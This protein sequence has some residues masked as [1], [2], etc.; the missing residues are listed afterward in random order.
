MCA[1]VVFPF[2]LVGVVAWQT[3][4]AA[5]AQIEVEARRAVATTAEH[6]LKVLETRG[7]A[8]DLAD[9]ATRGLSCDAIRA[10]AN[11]PALL[12]R[13]PAPSPN[14]EHRCRAGDQHRLGDRAGRSHIICGTPAGYK[15]DGKSRL[16]RDYF[17]GARDGTF[18][19]RALTGR[20][21]GGLFFP[22][23]RR[24]SAPDGVFAGVVISSVDT[25]YLARTWQTMEP[26]LHGPDVTATRG[27]L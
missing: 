6:M 12:S 27:R 1:A 16:D 5:V 25:A 9:E 23:A 24:R 7:L 13:V 3:R 22:L 19:G 14:T 17:A 21:G 8:L 4:E 26:G 10:S 2:A 20:V 15:D 18:I 11:L